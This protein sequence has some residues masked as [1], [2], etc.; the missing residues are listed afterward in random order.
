MLLRHR[1]IEKIIRIARIPIL[2]T[3]NKDN[4]VTHKD[5]MS[6]KEFQNFLIQTADFIST[7]TYENISKIPKYNSHNFKKDM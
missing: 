4:Y 3:N 1:F 5:V 6:I 2:I 7:L